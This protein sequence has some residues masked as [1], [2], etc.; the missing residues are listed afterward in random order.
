[1]SRWGIYGE[2]VAVSK[3]AVSQTCVVCHNGRISS[4]SSTVGKCQSIVKMSKVKT[5]ITEA[6]FL[7]E[8]SN[9]GQQYNVNASSDII[10][11]ILKT[12]SRDK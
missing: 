11:Q 12:D 10:F 8:V 2:I 1:M 4:M 9:T 6:S 7:I 5:T 3:I